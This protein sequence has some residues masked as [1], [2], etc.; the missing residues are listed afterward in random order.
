MQEPAPAA[1]RTSQRG[2]RILIDPYHY[3]YHLNK[4]VPPNVHWSCTEKRRSRCTGTASTNEKVII[5]HWTKHCHEAD[6]VALNV[7]K[8]E[9]EILELARKHPRLSTHHLVSEWQKATMA[10][11]AQ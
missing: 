5:F 6:P 10:P 11:E 8:A 4:V 3:T 2:G 9:D 7:K 1:Y